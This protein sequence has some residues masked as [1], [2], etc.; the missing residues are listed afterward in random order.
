MQNQQQPAVRYSQAAAAGTNTTS[1]GNNSDLG[2]MTGNFLNEF[3]S[4]FSQL[5]NQNSMIISMLTT[6][7]SKFSH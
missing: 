2:N 1:T 3:Q 4:M 6:M 7:I 5:L